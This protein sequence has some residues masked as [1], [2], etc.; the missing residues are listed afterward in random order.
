ILTG[1]VCPFGRDSVGRAKSN[2][3]TRPTRLATA[4]DR[5]SGANA[6]AVTSLPVSL[7]SS[8]V[9]HLPATRLDTWTLPNRPPERRVS[10][11]GANATCSAPPGGEMLPRLVG[12][13]PVRSHRY[14]FLICHAPMARVL[15]S[16]EN[17]R[18]VVSEP[19]TGIS[20]PF[21]A[22]SSVLRHS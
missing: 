9:S 7:R 17:A 20:G 3:L 22:P 4:R 19:G 14:A 13:T 5:P 8:F 16:R 6:S 2:T 11:S 1:P 10:P 15:L 21:S 18:L 12:W